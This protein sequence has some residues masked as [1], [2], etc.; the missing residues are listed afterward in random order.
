V[1]HSDHVFVLENGAT[2]FDGDAE[3][4]LDRPEIREAYLKVE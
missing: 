2:H 3:T 4:V 1:K